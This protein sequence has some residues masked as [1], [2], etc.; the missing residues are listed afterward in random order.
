MK[1]AAEFYG[2]QVNGKGQ[3]IC[4]FHKDR[5]PSMKIY[6]HNRGYYCFSCGSG[7]DVI[8][9]V[10]ALYG[11]KN[12]DAARKLI[13]DF[14]LPIKTADLSYREKREREQK[15][16]KRKELQELMG[17]T[18]RILRL[19]RIYLCEALRRPYSTHFDEA[20]QMISIVDYRLEC[21]KKYPQELLA[22]K[23]VVKWI[24]TVEQRLIGWNS[25]V[26]DGRTVSG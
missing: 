10:A 23:R 15:V 17:L 21:L 9:F 13:G 7:G 14:A 6:P 4:P 16:R 22:D 1:Q 8:K 12:E 19:Y 25:A 24:G 11:L 18:E 3:C 5:H 2:Y 20:L 26:T